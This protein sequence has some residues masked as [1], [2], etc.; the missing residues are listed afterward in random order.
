MENSLSFLKSWTPA[1]F[2]T[3]FKL[4]GKTTSLLA[5][6]IAKYYSDIT[7]LHIDK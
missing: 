7:L 3:D 2:L 6:A 4:S 1:T 5:P